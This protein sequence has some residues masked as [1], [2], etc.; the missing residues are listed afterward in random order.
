MPLRSRFVLTIIFFNIA[1]L[2][3]CGGGGGI[4]HVIPPPPTGNFT[5]SNLNGTYVFSVIGSDVN[6]LPLQLTGTLTAD[7]NGNITGG[8]FDVNNPNGLGVGNLSVGSGST[9]GVTADGRATATVN[10]ASGAFGFAFV[11]TSSEHGLITEF[12]TGGTGSGALD[13][14]TAV[15]QTQVAQSYALS[16]SGSDGGLN[17]MASLAGFTL[18]GA[19]TVGNGVQ[20]INDFTTVL[21]Q[22][23]LSG[24]VL[25]GAAGAP[26]TAQL[27][28]QT[29]LG[30]LTFDVYAIDA[31]HLKFIETDNLA[32]LVGDA[33]PQQTTIPAATNVFTVAGLD[34]IQGFPIVAGGF[35]VTDGNGNV[36]STSN[37]DIN[38]GGAVT[39]A[40]GFA[41][42]YTAVVNGR[43]TMT[44]TGFNNAS[45]SSTTT[46]AA[47]PTTNGLQLLEIDTSGVTSGV[48]TS[49]SSTTLASGQ[50]YGLNLTGANTNG[51]ED[52]IAQFT[53]TS[54]SLSGLVDFNDQGNLTPAQVFAGTYAADSTNTGRGQVSSSAF[55][56]ISYVVDNSTT[57][58]IEQDTNQVGVGVFQSQNASVKSNLAANHLAG[59]RLKPGTKPAKGALKRR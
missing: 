47:Y 56:L 1:V 16:L 2:A 17:P 30:T 4:S 24:T 53:N 31:N 8:A 23:T 55:N 46:F 35:I 20:D 40:I 12:D 49:Q 27:V 38:D 50:T 41:G 6:G 26:G 36:S 33:F 29:T 54:G 48:A 7:G 25:V 51:Q 19:G 9:F 15:S 57:V 42:L 43:S 44:L 18:D 5:N 28:T 13:L 11:L 32:F 58:F 22:L 14:Q 3:S 21:P 37:E 34:L 52:D 45:L 39:T 59:L 10:T